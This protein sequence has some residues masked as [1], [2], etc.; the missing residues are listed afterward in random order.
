MYLEDT[1]LSACMVECRVSIIGDAI[2][3]WAS[4][5]PIESV[6]RLVSLGG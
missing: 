4:I 5:P 6:R 1:F 2:M 3:V